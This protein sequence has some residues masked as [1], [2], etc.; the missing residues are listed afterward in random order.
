MLY[1]MD[2]SRDAPLARLFHRNSAITEATDHELA[3]SIQ[4]FAEGQHQGAIVRGRTWPAA[5]R[6]TLP[7]QKSLPVPAQALH[8]VL[9][10]RR[11]IRSYSDKPLSYELLASWLH[12]SY[13]VTG[14]VQTEGESGVR[15]ELRAAP[16]GGALYPIELYVGAVNCTGVAHGIYHYHAAQHVLEQLGDEHSANSLRTQLLTGLEG[17]QKPAVVV[18]LSACWAHTLEKYGER[19]YRIAHLDAGH[20]AQNL[21][22]TAT[23]LGFGACPL[24]GFY[25][26]RVAQELKLDPT[27]EP[28]LYAMMAGMV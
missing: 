20:V 16:S 9:S 26:L 17:L 24:A 8:K 4:R 11:S 19:G 2:M 15:M 18:I 25:D 3:A 22:L 5:P 1:I 12:Y 6:I 28:I 23:A 14:T 10:Q 27:Q 7:P 21:L 13:G